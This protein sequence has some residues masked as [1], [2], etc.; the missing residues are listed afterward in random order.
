MEIQLISGR[1]RVSEAEQLLTEIVKVKI[2]F[3]AQKIRTV[4]QTEEDIKHS[5][6]RII[7][8]EKT[9]R[10]AIE[11]MKENNMEYTNIEAHI[12]VKFPIH[13]GQ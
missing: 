5:E 12:D 6:N 10:D 4:H 1:F 7:Q 2:A 9:L 8:L 11:K 3:H 13:V